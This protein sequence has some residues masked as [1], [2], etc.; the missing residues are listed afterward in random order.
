MRRRSG[1][2]GQHEEMGAHTGKTGW[3]GG[4]ELGGGRGELRRLRRS[5]WT[6]QGK[7]SSRERSGPEIEMEEGKV[8][9]NES[10]GREW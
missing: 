9:E 4:S 8:R 7:R 1:C 5:R 10:L 2:Q 6:W 3:T